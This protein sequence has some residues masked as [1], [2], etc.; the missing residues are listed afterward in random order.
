M[1]TATTGTTS[2]AVVVVVVNLNFSKLLYPVMRSK[3]YFFAITSL[4]VV[5]FYLSNFI[6]EF[7][8]YVEIY[9]KDYK[10]PIESGFSTGPI[11][12][13]TQSF[14]KA[15]M[16]ETILANDTFKKYRNESLRYFGNQYRMQNLLQKIFQ[17]N[18]TK[19]NILITG[20]SVSVNRVLFYVVFVSSTLSD[21][22]YILQGGDTYPNVFREEISKAA[23]HS[24]LNIEIVTD[25]ISRGATCT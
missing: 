4:V 8:N 5:Y 18:K 20:G 17:G 12:S 7:G 2:L 6:P 9:M 24:G 13:Q 16:T 14:A 1:K 3:C 22:M 15:L 23:N 25:N 10:Q 19:L 21:F 11:S